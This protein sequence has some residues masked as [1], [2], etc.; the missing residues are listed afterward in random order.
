MRRINMYV[1]I[2]VGEKGV[3]TKKSWM[4]FCACPSILLLS[5]NR[6]PAVQAF[7]LKTITH[8]F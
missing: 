5:S 4:H 1:F 7:I 3:V 8:V 6:V 2:V